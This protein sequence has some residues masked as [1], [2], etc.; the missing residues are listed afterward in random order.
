MELH[1]IAHLDNLPSILRQGILSHNR[2][3]RHRPVSVANPEIQEI[4]HTKRVP[5]GHMLHDYVNLYISARNAMLFQ[6]LGFP[7]RPPT[8]HLSICVVSVSADVLDLPGVVITDRNA[9]SSLSIFL[10]SPNGLRDLEKTLVFGR[11]W[12]D[13]DPIEEMKKKEC[14]MAEVLVPDRIDPKYII[15]LYVCCQQSKTVASRSGPPITV[16]VNRDLFFNAGERYHG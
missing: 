7:D 13:E 4:R 2:S 5:G 11:Y 1:Y 3:Q 8:Q 15:G 10:P 16:T 14:M 12:K 9:A 6:V